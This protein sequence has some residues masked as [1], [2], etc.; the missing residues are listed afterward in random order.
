MPSLKGKISESDLGSVADYMIANF[1]TPEFV[2]MI[3]EIQK[4]D[5]MNALLNS[6]FLMNQEALPHMTS[7]LIQ[8]WDKTS[9]GLSAEQ[10]EKLLVVRQNTMNAVLTIKKKVKVLEDQI[11]EALVDGED[12][13][14]VYVK[15]DEVA[16][17]K[18]EAT[19][20]HLKCISD[21]INILNEEQMELLFPFWDA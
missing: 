18:A 11:I 21:T 13:K 4:N 15:V 8:N 17:L 2:T 6:P 10:K 20:V 19:K 3:K 12:P 5:K 14:S 16:K 7:I 9:L 1:P